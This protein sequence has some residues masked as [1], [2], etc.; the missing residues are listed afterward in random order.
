MVTVTGGDLA[1]MKGK[2]PIMTAEE[3]RARAAAVRAQGLAL[4]HPPVSQQVAP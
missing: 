1:R 2:A 4:G 3:V